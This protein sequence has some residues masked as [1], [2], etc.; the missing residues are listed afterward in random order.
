MT[1]LLLLPLYPAIALLA[2][3]SLV[4]ACGLLLASLRRV[5]MAWKT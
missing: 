4:L 1:N 2:K 3:A 5:G